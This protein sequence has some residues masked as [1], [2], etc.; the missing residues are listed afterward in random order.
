MGKRDYRKK[1]PKKAK[2]DSRKVTAAEILPS[3][4]AVEVVRGKRKRREGEEE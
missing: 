3:T 4:V 1:E 2:K